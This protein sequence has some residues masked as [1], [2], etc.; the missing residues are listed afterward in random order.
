ML[1]TEMVPRLAVDFEVEAADVDDFDLTDAEATE[2]FVGEF[3]PRLVVNCAAYTDVDGAE[4]DPALAFAVNATGAGGLATAARRVGARF[5]HISTDYVF[6]GSSTRPYVEDDTPNPIGAY[7]RS[8]LEG[9][10]LVRSA[11]PDA[12]VVRTAWLYGHAGP[13]FVEKMISLAQSGARLRVVNDQ[14]GS[15]TNARDLASAVAEL[16]AVE[17]SGVVN[18]TNTGTCTWFE[19]AEEALRLAGLGDVGLTPVPTS[20]FQTPARRPAYSV[21][22]LDRLTGLTGSRPRGWREALAEYITER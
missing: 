8:K 12:L 2:R 15:P 22:S 11:C 16:V 9:E 13:N 17:A 3:E 18:A 4:S 20:E 19:F 1:G 7:G 21:L 5:V 10:I 14:T 6:D